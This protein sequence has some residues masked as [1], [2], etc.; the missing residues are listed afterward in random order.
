MGR[1][2]ST[3]SATSRRRGNRGLE[4]RQ[5]LQSNLAQVRTQPWSFDEHIREDTPSLHQIVDRP[6]RWLTRRVEARQHYDRCR[7]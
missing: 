1:F 2:R 6:S 7:C 3:R 5:S 4:L